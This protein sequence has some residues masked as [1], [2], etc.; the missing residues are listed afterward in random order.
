FLYTIILN[1]HT[2]NWLYTALI[3]GLWFILPAYIANMAA[4]DVA[5]IPFLKKYNRPI[6]D[7]KLYKGQPIF[8]KGKTWRGFIGGTLI[9]TFAGFL[10]FFYSSEAMV[11]ISDITGLESIQLPEMTVILAF[12]ISLGAMTGD[13]VASFGKR[14]LKLKRGGPAPLLDQLDYI[15]GAFFFSWLVTPI[16]LDYFALI[17]IVSIPLHLGANIVAWLLKMKQVWW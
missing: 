13:L 15:F 5:H 12:L 2:M 7:G 10:Q 16:N 1:N 6:D 14:R 11:L 17:V 4:I 3:S 9:G 8:G